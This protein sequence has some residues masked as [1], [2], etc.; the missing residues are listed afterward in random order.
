MER[1][2]RRT[3]DARGVQPGSGGGVGVKPPLTTGTLLM[4][5]SP[6]TRFYLRSMRVSNRRFK[7]ATGWSPRYR[8]AASGWRQM[9]TN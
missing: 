5:L 9:V 4:R 3:V 1:D 7:E 8:D 6:N 2:R